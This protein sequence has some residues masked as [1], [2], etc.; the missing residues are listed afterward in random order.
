MFR[1]DNNY[2]QSIAKE[3]HGQAVKPVDDRYVKG[4]HTKSISHFSVG[5]H[6]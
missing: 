5:G 1:L 6:H 4:A 2:Y 3:N